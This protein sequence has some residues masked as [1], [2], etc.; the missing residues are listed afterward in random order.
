MECGCVVVYCRPLIQHKL[1]ILGKAGLSKDNF[2]D[3][4]MRELKV[5]VYITGR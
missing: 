4:D 3:T 2:C 5:G 1:N